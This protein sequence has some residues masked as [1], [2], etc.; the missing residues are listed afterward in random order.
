VVR[1]GIVNVP[2]NPYQFNQTITAR[3]NDAQASGLAAQLRKINKINFYGENWQKS[4]TKQLAKTYLLTEAYLRSE[5]IEGV[6][7]EDLTTLIGWNTPKEEVLNTQGIL[8][9]WYVLSKTLEEEDKLTT[10]RVWLYG[11]AS[12][13]MALILN[14]YAFNQLPQNL[15]AKGS[16]VKAEMFF[17]PSVLPFRALLKQQLGIENDFLPLEGTKKIEEALNHISDSISNQPFID[18]IP[19]ILNDFVLLLKDNKWWLGDAFEQYVSLENTVEE[20]WNILAISQGKPF[21]CFVIYEDEKFIIHTLWS[22]NSIY[23]IK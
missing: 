7:K 17:Y 6:L 12:K 5:Q 22:G 18:K 1:T 21:D 11:T 23:F 19:L 4:L 2:Q 8:D 10:E 15:L 9:D 16:K 3:M 20:A 14:F 13:R